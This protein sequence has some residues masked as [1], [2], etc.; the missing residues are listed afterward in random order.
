MLFSD[1]STAFNILTYIDFTKRFTDDEILNYMNTIVQKNPILQ[2]RIYSSGGNHYLEKVDSFDLQDQYAMVELSSEDFDCQIEKEVN[3]GFQTELQWKFIWCV[4]TLTQKHRLIFKIHHS[5]ADGYRLI[6]IL[7]S[8]FSNK[9]QMKRFERKTTF[10]N[11]LYYIIFGTISIVFMILYFFLQVALN[12]KKE[13]YINKKT[14]IISCKAFSFHKLHT[15]AKQHKIK[16]NDL[17][18]SILV[19]TDKLYY[20]LD[21]NI[22]SVSP[23]NVSKDELTNNMMPVFITLQNTYESSELYRKIHE[24]FNCF[25]YSAFMPLFKMIILFAMKILPMQYFNLFYEVILE[26]S[27]YIY[28]NIIGPPRKDIHPDIEDIHFVTKAKDH[29]IIYN[30][31]SYE[32]K[33]NIVLSFQEGVIQDKVRFEECIYKAYEE[34]IS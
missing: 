7:T 30:I 25:K 19:R 2:Q 13:K 12:T 33:I 17:L 9:D 15:V 24:I 8:P 1:E 31:I 14:V 22:L 6:E 34:L 18:F 32:D 21:R 28:S 26:Q 10:F 16:V 4:N 27:D 29:E 23:I 11:A 20:Q 5:Y 3:T